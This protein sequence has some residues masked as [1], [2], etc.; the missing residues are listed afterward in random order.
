MN[1]CN[2]C[3]KVFKG[4]YLQEQIRTVHEKLKQHQCNICH[5]SF[6]QKES[7]NRHVKSVHGNNKLFKCELCDFSACLHNDT[8]NVSMKI[9][10][11]TNVIFA[12]RPLVR[13]VH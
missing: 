8:L 11:H 7:L 10:N 9:S 2:I 5:E 3:E 12:K 13:K 6:G 1:K 4:N